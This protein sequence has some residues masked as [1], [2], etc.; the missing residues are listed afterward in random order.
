M[1]VISLDVDGLECESHLACVP[2]PVGVKAEECPHDYL[3]LYD[4]PD[5][6]SRVI[7]TLCGWSVLLLLMLL[8]LLPLPATSFLPSITKQFP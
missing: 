4:G 3:V 1:E 5:E 2:R 6:R 8:M 7:A